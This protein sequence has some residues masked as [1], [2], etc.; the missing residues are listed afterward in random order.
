MLID[1]VK[2]IGFIILAYAAYYFYINKDEVMT[3]VPF[4]IAM[5]GV[6]L[7]RLPSD[8]KLTVGTIIGWILVF[9][10][11]SQFIIGFDFGTYSEGN[12]LSICTTIGYLVGISLLGIEGEDSEYIDCD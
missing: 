12:A 6:A 11:A 8:I 1:I 9:V 5:I 3:T 7:A 4:G 2:I 10:G